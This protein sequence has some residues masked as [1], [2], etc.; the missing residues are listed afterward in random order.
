M[1]N[2]RPNKPVNTCQRERNRGASQMR[3]S[4]GQMSTPFPNC[5]SQQT[6]TEDLVRA[7]E[8]QR[9]P[10]IP[11]LKTLQYSWENNMEN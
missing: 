1:S 3:K 2:G 4:P 8:E 9:K 7:K 6:R 10:L 5:F 11:E